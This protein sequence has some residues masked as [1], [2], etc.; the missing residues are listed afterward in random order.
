MHPPDV[1]KS[2][3]DEYVTDDDDAEGSGADRDESDPRSKVQFVGEVLLPTFAPSLRRSGTIVENP[4]RPEDV[5]VLADG[6]QGQGQGCNECVSRLTDATLLQREADGHQSVDG[7]GDQEPDGDV[8]G[9]VEGELLRATCPV[10][11]ISEPELN[12]R[13]VQ[14]LRNDTKDESG[15][16]GDCDQRQVD[17]RRCV[18]K[19]LAPHDEEGQG[20]AQHP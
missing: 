6:H 2:S 12:R 20:V 18:A 17:A 1:R 15:R 3:N 10:V 4:T 5:K 9:R 7:E 11:E 16:V 14:E 8:A 13:S 19:S